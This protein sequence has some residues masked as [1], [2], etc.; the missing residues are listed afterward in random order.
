MMMMIKED[1]T[2][3]LITRGPAGVAVCVS[4]IGL[5]SLPLANPRFKVW[6]KTAR[7]Y[8]GPIP[9]WNHRQNATIS[10]K[11]HPL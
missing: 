9:L 5:F 4:K 10:K 6:R 7:A 3:T 8:E 11:H 2:E 1:D